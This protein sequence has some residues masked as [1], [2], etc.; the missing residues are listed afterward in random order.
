MGASDVWYGVVTSLEDRSEP[1][2]RASDHPFF[3]GMNPGWV[4]TVSH[5]SVDA[6]YDSG[7]LLVREGEV[8][9]R[10]HL[11]FHGR[12]AV[13]VSGTSGNRWTVQTIGPGEAVDWPA[14]VPP[15]VWRFNGR[16][17]QETRVLSLDATVLRRAL[18]SD[19]VEGYRFLGRLVPMIGRRLENIRNRWVEAADV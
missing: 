8:A 18:G 16:A 7:E 10:F 3:R 9:N 15:H 14:I 5:G 11:V 13:E 12:L 6:T 2:I 17:L 4:D 19:P 1:R